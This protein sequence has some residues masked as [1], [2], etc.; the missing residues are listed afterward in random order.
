MQGMEVF[1]VYAV[2]IINLKFRPNTF[3]CAFRNEDCLDDIGYS[4]L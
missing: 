3:D 4:I 1:T 2:Q